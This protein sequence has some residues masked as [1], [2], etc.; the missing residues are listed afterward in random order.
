MT[1]AFIWLTVLV[2]AFVQ[3]YTT[4]M[5]HG[6]L[7]KLRRLFNNA[8]P[9]YHVLQ[10]DRVPGW[11]LDQENIDELVVN[12]AR[13]L[14]EVQADPDDDS[15][16]ITSIRLVAAKNYTPEFHQMTQAINAYL[17]RNRGAAADFSILRDITDRSTDVLISEA[18]QSIPVPLYL[19]LSGTLVCAVAG[20]SQLAGGFASLSS[21]DPQYFSQSTGNLV[22]HVA[23]AMVTSALGVLLTVYNS[24][25]GFKRALAQIETDRN[26]FLSYLQAELLP[27]MSVTANSALQKLQ[28]ALKS[29]NNSFTRNLTRLEAAFDKTV[30]L[31]QLQADTAQAFAQIDADKMA[32]TA[33]AMARAGT[34]V[35]RFVEG[36]EQTEQWLRASQ[37][38][39][40]RVESLLQRT[41]RVGKVVLAL[42]TGVAGVHALNQ[43]IVPHLETLRGVAETVQQG[44]R[45]E[46]GQAVDSYKSFITDELIPKNQ[47][48][49]QAFTQEI[50]Q[51]TDKISGSLESFRLQLVQQQRALD[52]TLKAEKS[53]LT[54]LKKLNDLDDTL[55]SILLT[56]QRQDRQSE[57]S[58]VGRFSGL[59]PERRG[60]LNRAWMRFRLWLQTL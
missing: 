47:R 50:S 20:L 12:N 17:I 1:T 55:K 29:F 49:A 5:L 51:T 46:V 43:T 8:G 15:S 3:L 34:S 16:D 60:P 39:T 14:R 36:L 59:A 56:L 13:A 42:E 57:G 37:E 4:Y 38:L 52:D 23:L 7:G 58:T 30:S 31:S 45:Q 21:Q 2:V 9:T 44:F 35:G 41:D 54:N 6:R 48:A 26:H 24:N 53:S 28:E 32:R 33:A 22:G 19:G 11:A 40:E 27:H 25:F 18:E 10:L